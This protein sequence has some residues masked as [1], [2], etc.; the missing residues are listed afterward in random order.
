MI[1]E[2]ENYIITHTGKNI[3]RILA[4]NYAHLSKYYCLNHS[5]RVSVENTY[6]IFDAVP[7]ASME[8]RLYHLEPGQYKIKRHLLN[9]E[10]GSILDQM[11]RMWFQGNLS[12]ERLTY[13]MHNLSAKETEYFERTCIPEQTIFYRESDGSLNLNCK[14]AAHEVLFFEITREL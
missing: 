6:S 8:F 14:I 1:C 10:H 11:A 4:F 7:T 3:F 2:G 13:N 5:D 12:F 9:R